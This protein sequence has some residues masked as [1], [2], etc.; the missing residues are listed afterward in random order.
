MQNNKRIIRVLVLVSFMFLALVS[1]LL[2]FNM[3]QAEKVS[4]NPY[5][6]RQW[7]DER[8]VKR[9]SIYDRDGELLAETVVDGDN[10]TRR[11]P[12][13]RLYSHIIGY[14]SRVYG[15]NLLEMNYD[16]ELM[17]H[18]DINLSF[19]EIRS[20]YDLNL[21]IDN[22]LQKYAYDKL[23]GRSGCRNGTVNG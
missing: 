1:Y 6:K 10:R 13:G 23:N 3:F 15:K 12:K 22:D 21:T 18:G 7:E 20:G 8:Y 19:N 17:G 11:Y 2:Y 5:N 14:Y 16:K 4:S 9:G